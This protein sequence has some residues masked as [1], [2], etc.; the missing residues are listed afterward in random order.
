M[1][2]QLIQRLGEMVWY[3]LDRLATIDWAGWSDSD[4]V[5]LAIVAVIVGLLALYI[6]NLLI[7]QWRWWL[8]GGAVIVVFLVVGVFFAQAQMPGPARP[9]SS[10]GLQ[11]PW[12][13]WLL[14]IM[15]LLLW[16][17]WKLLG[18]EGRREI[19]LRLVRRALSSSLAL[20]FLG[21]PTPEW[22]GIVP[23]P[24][25]PEETSDEEV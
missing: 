18:P 10:R 24:V 23:Q 19:R 8:M 15:S 11:A 7:Y 22:A 6:I 4:V 9:A 21:P 20:R 5:A 3:F 16:A 25:E 13:I 2:L 14:L 1:D 12:W 17:I